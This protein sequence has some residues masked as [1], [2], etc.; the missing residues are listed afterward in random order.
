VKPK[1]AMQLYRE[2]MGRDAADRQ[3]ALADRY[4]VCC[5]NEKGKPHAVG[6][7]NVTARAP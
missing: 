2:M 3:I 4:Y 7:R 5:G 1:E 6:C